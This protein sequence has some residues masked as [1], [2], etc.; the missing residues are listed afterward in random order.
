MSY[1]SKMGILGQTQFAGTL[2]AP[3]S[4][5]AVDRTFQAA[6]A[7]EFEIIIGIAEF[8]VIVKRQLIL[9]FD[10]IWCLLGGIYKSNTLIHH[11]QCISELSQNKRRRRLILEGPLP[12]I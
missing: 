5:Q 10:T 6:K 1:F 4:V 11:F 8:K 12:E 2:H 9:Y 7:T 3:D